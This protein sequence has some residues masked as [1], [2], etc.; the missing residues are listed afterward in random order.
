VS[1][2]ASSSLSPAPAAIE[3]TDEFNNISFRDVRVFLVLVAR[4]SITAAAKEL[5][6]TQSG[7]SRAIQALEEAVGVQLFERTRKGVALTGA[8]AAFVEYA[9]Q[10]AQSYADAVTSVQ[11]GHGQYLTFAT[12]SAIAP[13]ILPELLR[14][15]KFDQIAD[16]LVL[17]ELPSHQVAAQVASGAADLGL[18]MCANTTP[19]SE[20]EAIPLRNAALG[21][22]TYA[23]V[24]VPHVLPSFAALGHL[25]RPAHQRHLQLA[26]LADD[27]VL[28]QALRAYSAQHRVRF[29]AYFES[30]LVCNNM[31]ALLS[32]VAGGHFVALVSAIAAHS[33]PPYLKFLPLPHLLPALTLC[34]VY[35]K[36]SDTDRLQAEWIA[37]IVASVD[38]VPWRTSVTQA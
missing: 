21:L 3:S 18:C 12:S 17:N 37:A 33:A 31:P 26:R 34:L 13:L 9:R 32:A 24:R 29:D 35:R 2:P 10:L 27:M 16:G 36:G 23:D 6:L 19:H 1:Q 38:A 7:L 4:R 20:V 8:G 22:L 28:P 25:T 5:H 11:A 15:M 30:R 14:R